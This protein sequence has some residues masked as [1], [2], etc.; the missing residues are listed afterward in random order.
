MAM[1]NLL[2]Q[3]LKK[4]GVE[5]YSELTEVEKTTYQ[6]WEQILGREVKI[7]NV[8]E[9]LETQVKRL[10]KELRTAVLEGE[11]RK[12]LQITAKIENFEAIIMFI[13]EPTERRKSL[14]KQLLT[15]VT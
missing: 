1:Q 11:D 2:V 4:L 5:D 15:Q 3:F 12:S 14:E 13:K 6:E 10:N 8:A 7:E 9:F